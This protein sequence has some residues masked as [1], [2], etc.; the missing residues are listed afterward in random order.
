MRS[1]DW[2]SDVCSSDL[3]VQFAR[4]DTLSVQRPESFDD[5]ADFSFFNPETGRLEFDNGVGDIDSDDPLVILFAPPE[6]KTADGSEGLGDIDWD[7][8][9]D[10]VGRNEVENRRTTIRSWFG[11]RGDAWGDYWK[12]EASVGYGDFTQEQTRSKIGR[13]HV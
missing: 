12:W 9:F 4:E 7:R 13:A 3:H 2:S 6:L 11:A 1:S 5:A 10:E 8:R